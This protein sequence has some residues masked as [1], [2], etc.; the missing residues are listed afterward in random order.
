MN[1]LASRVR[2][3]LQD[4]RGSS[5]RGRAFGMIRPKVEQTIAGFPELALNTRRLKLA[6]LDRNAELVPSHVSDG[7]QRHAGTWS[8]LRSGRCPRACAD[9][10]LVC[11]HQVNLAEPYGLCV[12]RC[13]LTV[14]ET[15]LGDRINQM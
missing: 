11:G 5:A 4:E 14:I 12:D 15:D 9:P 7:G 6:A 8:I 1:A 13:S 2:A 10:P 3:A